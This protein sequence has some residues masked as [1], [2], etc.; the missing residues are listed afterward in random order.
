[1]NYEQLDQLYQPPYGDRAVVL[2]E[3]NRLIGAAGFV[4]SLAPFGQIPSLRSEGSPEDGYR[5]EVGL[6]WAIAPAYQGHGYAT[7]A[8]R[9]MI[10]FGFRQLHLRRI[11]ATTTYDNSASIRV[12]EK[13][14][15]RIERNPYPNPPWLQV[16]GLLAREAASPIGPS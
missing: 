15:M 13:V 14:G 7:E 6:F 11:V 4:P 3:T 12:M 5:P 16:V 10:E 8:A 9:A 1:M 2:K